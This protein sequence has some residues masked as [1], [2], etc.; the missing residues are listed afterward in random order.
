MKRLKVRDLRKE[1]YWTQSQLAA[2]I[3]VQ[4]QTIANIESG[5]NNPHPTTLHK[6]ANAFGVP[7]EQLFDDEE[8][9]AV[10]AA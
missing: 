4:A 8:K 9:P 7:I 2:M 5:R 6:L 3:G 10:P 1:R